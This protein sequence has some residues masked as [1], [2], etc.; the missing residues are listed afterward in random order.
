V[1]SWHPPNGTV[2]RES[3]RDNVTFV[4]TLVVRVYIVIAGVGMLDGLG[5]IRVP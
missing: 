2:T 4:L 5:I 1:F 3:D